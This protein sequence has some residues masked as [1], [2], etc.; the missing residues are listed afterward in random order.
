MFRL[1]FWP[2]FG[3]DN[4]DGNDGR[5]DDWGSCLP[6]VHARISLSGSVEEFGSKQ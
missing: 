1:L 4:D 2:F 5:E 6:A 3:G